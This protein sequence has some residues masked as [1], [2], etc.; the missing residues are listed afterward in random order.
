[1]R[2]QK[3]GFEGLANIIVSQMI[4]RAAAEHIWERLSGLSGGA[5]DAG[6]LAQK[7]I[8]ALK[9]IGLSTAKAST[10]L[11]VAEAVA[12]GTLD[13]QGI[14]R[15]PAR[16]ASAEL[17]AIKGIG[18]W[19]AEVYLMFCA[20]HADMFPVGDVA[21]QNAVGHAFKLEARPKGKQLLQ[22]AEKWQPWRSVAA[23]LFWAYYSKEV[24]R[25]TNLFG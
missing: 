5:V 16:E 15:L 17:T 23:R 1:L 3:P 6:V 14:C 13:L 7:D 8:A 22:M 19:T 20:G 12:G 4:S 10:V 18:N 21:L 9:A 25:E 24:R 2:L 11:R